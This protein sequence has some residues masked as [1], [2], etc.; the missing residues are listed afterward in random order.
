ML[1]CLLSF[2]LFHWG[3]LTLDYYYNVTLRSKWLPCGA[4]ITFKVTL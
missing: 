3:F 1:R 2:R 4:E